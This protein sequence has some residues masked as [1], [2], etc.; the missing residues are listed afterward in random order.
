MF[1]CPRCWEKPH[2]CQCDVDEAVSNAVSQSGKAA[3]TER[4]KVRS[5][6]HF[7]KLIT[8]ITGCIVS[9]GT[10]EVNT[11]RLYKNPFVQYMWERYQNK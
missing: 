6:E 9:D 4:G 8:E 3:P 10:L 11:K 1:S 5:R 2:F 7:E